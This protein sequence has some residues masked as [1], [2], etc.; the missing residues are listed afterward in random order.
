MPRHDRSMS[1]SWRVTAAAAL[2]GALIV[3]LA[4]FGAPALAGGT[5]GSH[6]PHGKKSGSSQY[7]Y[8]VPLCHRTHS[9]KHPWVLLRISSRSVVVH[10]LRHGDRLAPCPTGSHHRSKHHHGDRGK[11]H[12]GHHDDDD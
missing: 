9:R 5:K 4:L 6:H 7:E 10:L 2:T 3:P 1:R 8:T 11:D 12:G